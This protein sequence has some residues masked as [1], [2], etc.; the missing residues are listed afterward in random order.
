MYG[1]FYP[2]SFSVLQF[3]EHLKTKK[4]LILHLSI[5]FSLAP[6]IFITFHF[7]T[8]RL[9]KLVLKREVFMPQYME[10]A[11][12]YDGRDWIFSVSIM[13]ASTLAPWL[14]VECI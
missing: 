10:S 5:A 9:F 11:N 8:N 7:V 2:L 13:V 3:C 4:G 1:A 12:R 6:L 14:I